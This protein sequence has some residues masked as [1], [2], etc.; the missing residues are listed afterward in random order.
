MRWDNLVR[1]AR[2]LPTAAQNVRATLGTA[3]IR[4]RKRILLSWGYY[5]RGWVQPFQSLRHRFD[6]SYVYYVSPP[7]D[8]VRCAEGTYFYWSDFEDAD[9]LIE[10]A[11]PDA[12][13]FMSVSSGYALA[14]NIAA[15]RKGIPT[16]VL[17]H[18][19]QFDYAFYRDEETRM[20]RQRVEALRDMKLARAPMQA[21]T[22]KASGS[23]A[24]GSAR[25]VLRSMTGPS[26]FAAPLALTYL[27]LARRYGHYHAARRLAFEARRP[28]RYICFTRQTRP[29]TPK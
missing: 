5:R 15:K 27:A 11:A 7:E 8:E 14:L 24:G 26:V 12:V 25:F 18:G 9:A 6:F 17:Q 22:S 10:A 1:R 29:S 3:V 16:F 20:R 4:E 21:S 23:S 19:I 2:V 28:S 13:G